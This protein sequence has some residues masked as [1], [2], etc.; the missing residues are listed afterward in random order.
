M[1]D[2]LHHIAQDLGLSAEL[3]ALRIIARIADGGLRDAESLLD[4]VVAF[5]EGKITS[6]AV[7]EVLGV[8]PRDILFRMDKAGKAGNLSQ[9]FEI[10]HEVFSQGKDLVHFIE[11]LVEHFRNLLVVKLTGPNASELILSESDRTGYS[12]SALLYTQEQCLNLLDYL[13]E[14]QQQVRYAPSSR[15]A[16]EATLLHIMRI[17]QRIPVEHL[18][19]QM[20]ELEQRLQGQPMAPAAPAPLAPLPP[21]PPPVPVAAPSIT[22]DPIPTPADLGKKPQNLKETMKK[23]SRYD[24][25]TQFAAV[26]LGGSLKKH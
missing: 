25:V 15:I 23:Q 6:E 26:E 14:A 19:K 1:V 24:T 3:D 10:A 20:I 12:Q 16:L 8:M 11:A 7:S 13:M 22:E 5:H 18:V 9:A 2:A 17:H 21:T 4:Q